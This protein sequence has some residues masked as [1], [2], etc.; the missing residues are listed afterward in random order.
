MM[1]YEEK[2]VHS[3]NDCDECCFNLACIGPCRLKKGYHYATSM[4]VRL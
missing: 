3:T 1:Y 4:D 2:T